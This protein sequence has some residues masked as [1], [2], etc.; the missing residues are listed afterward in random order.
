MDA[1]SFISCDKYRGPLSLDKV[2]GKPW[3]ANMF[4]KAVITPLKV[5][6]F[7]IMTSGNLEKIVDTVQI[8]LTP[9][10]DQR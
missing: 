9:E 6:L 3:Q 2:S 4:F 5:V 8:S 7:S 1:N 10:I